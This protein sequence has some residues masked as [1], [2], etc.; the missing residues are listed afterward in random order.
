MSAQ[1]PV[2]GQ[3]YPNPPAGPDRAGSGPHSPAPADPDAKA[4]A[5]QD[6]VI[7]AYVRVKTGWRV[8]L[9]RRIES[10]DPGW[11]ARWGPPP[12]PQAGCKW[13]FV[14]VDGGDRVALCP[15]CRPAREGVCDRGQ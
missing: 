5:V 13:G 12:C 8:P 4:W 15:V 1:R 7:G 14:D 6:E 9:D 3:A 11:F 10:A 2:A